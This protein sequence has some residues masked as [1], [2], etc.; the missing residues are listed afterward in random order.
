[1]VGWRTQGC[2]APPFSIWG[3]EV[4]L[5]RVLSRLGVVGNQEA[6]SLVERGR[7]MDTN[8]G[9]PPT[10][11]LRVHQE[12]EELGLQDMSSPNREA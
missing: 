9:W 10:K 1:M 11:R 4:Q 12:W 8:N 3:E 6:E 2:I 7:M 5:K